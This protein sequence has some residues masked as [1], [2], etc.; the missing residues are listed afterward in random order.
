MILSLCC[1]LFLT[2]GVQSAPRNYHSSLGPE[3][4]CL[5]ER[6]LKMKD[7]YTDVHR[8]GTLIPEN[9]E[10]IGNYLMCVWK[11]RQIVDTDLHVHSEN[12]ARYFYDIYFKLKLTELEKEEIKDA[13][14]V[15]EEEHAIEEYMLGLNLK[16]CMF[17]VAGTLEFLK[18]KP[19]E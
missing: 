11:K 14:K 18:R 17:K 19:V 16:D 2:I 15:C 12:I 6:H 4:E 10:R 7:V 8:E 1:I 13:V 3:N 9:A 5:T